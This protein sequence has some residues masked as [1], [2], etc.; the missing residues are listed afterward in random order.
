MRQGSGGE[1]LGPLL[2]QLTI[3]GSY[4][5]AN[6]AD[7]YWFGHLYFTAHLAPAAIPDAVNAVFVDRGELGRLPEDS[8]GEVDVDYPIDASQIRLASVARLGEH[9]AALAAKYPT[10]GAGKGA[11]NLN[12]NLPEVLAAARADQHQVDVDT[13]LVII[14]R[15]VLAWLVLFHVV[16]DAI[17][18][19]G[20]EVALAKLRGLRPRAVLLFTLGE[21]VTLVLLA[22]PLGLLL[23]LGVV[24]QLASSALVPGTPVTMTGS[25]VIAA[26]IACAGS[27]VAALLAGRRILTRPVLEQWRNTSSVPRSTRLTLVLEV[28]LTLAAVTGLIVLRVRDSPGSPNS[29]T[30]LAPALLVFGAGL[31]SVRALPALARRRIRPSRG[32]TRLGLFLSVRQLARRPAGL[33]LAALL[34]VAVG[35]ASF[36]VAGE[37]VARANRIARAQTELGAPQVASIQFQPSHDPQSVVAEVDPDGRWAMAAATWAPGGASAPA[38]AA[39]LVGPL[40]AVE[41]ARL[42]SVGYDVRAHL[43]MAA[44]ADAITVPNAR[45]ANFAGTQLRVR[46][47]GLSIL[48]SVPF[49]SLNV[50]RPHQLATT[51]RTT[52]L[53][54]GSHDYLASVDCAQGCSFVGIT[55]ER[56]SG[57]FDKEQ[58]SVRVTAVDSANGDNWTPVPAPL[59]DPQSWRAGS[60]GGAST[61]TLHTGA[62]GLQANFSTEDGTSALLVYADTPTRI[63]LVAAPAALNGPGDEGGL[64]DYTESVAAFTVVSRTA[65]LPGVL[66]AGAMGELIYLRTQLPDFDYEASW[67]IWLGPA[68]PVDAVA[69]LKAAG[70]IVQSVSTEHARVNTLGRQPPALAL[71]LLLVCAVAAAALAVGGT[72]ITLS[73]SGR[74]RSFELAA[75]RVIGVSTAALRRACV[76]EQLILLGAGLLAG[77]PCGIITAW[78]VMPVIPEF[79]DSTA[80]H[81]EFAPPVA[82][83]VIFALAFAVLLSLTA[84]VAGVS[85]ARAAVPARLREVEQ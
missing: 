52:A 32:S 59:T 28:L 37:G 54:L 74:R 39:S 24:H 82:P 8:G 34:A 75:L 10:H 35:L 84:V 22:L 14:E 55:W 83:L 69:R 62:D 40:L 66:A 27:G 38:G 50:R 61:A 47:D 78:V 23:A 2:D 56:P 46:V 6:T 49:V 65:V 44:I 43:P 81:L 17:E 68:A 31:L 67:A 18:A 25:A 42:P 3:V 79:S 36:A 80:V 16:A 4:R 21:P 73:A 57:E 15:A 7:P 9:V 71:L 30:L 1:Y 20:N 58:V 41:G 11:V 45:P 76:L 29:I 53:T 85:L 13:L 63:P 26:A 77:L 5:P 60:L 33:R 70:L 72:A 48:G 64:L 19:R 12:T 51:V